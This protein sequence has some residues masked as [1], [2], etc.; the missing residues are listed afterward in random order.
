MKK[1]DLLN[2][3][4][5]YHLAGATTSVKWIA[6]DGE[7]QT[8]FITDDQNVIGTINSTNLDLGNHDLGV[9]AT[10]A[11]VK[12]LSAVNED[13]GVNI[14]A[15]DKTAV[16]IDITDKDVNMTFMLADLSVIRQVPDLKNTP[17]WNASI[18]ITSDFRTKFIKAKNALPETE[19]FGVKCKDDKVEMIINYSTINTNRIK[20]EIETSGS[21][22]MNIICF[23][24]SLFKEIL[25]ANKD[26]E[27]GKLE[28]SSAGLARVTFSGKG[29]TSTYYLVQLQTA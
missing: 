8:N 18:N 11:L 12:M 15:V 1:N 2:F 10:P 5:R 20:F 7:L 22:D 19:N 17:D 25:Q 14:N 16:S 26:A 24:S 29:Y 13:L 6:K 27:S 28:M 21:T 23:S 9:Y 3:I 4:G